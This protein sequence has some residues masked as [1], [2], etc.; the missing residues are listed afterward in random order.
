MKFKTNEYEA[1]KKEEPILIEIT[2]SK[3]EEESSFKKK[4]EVLP[5][6][7]KQTRLNLS[8]E[9]KKTIVEFIEEYGYHEV[10]DATGM[11]HENLR[12]LKSR[13]QENSSSKKRGRK[14]MFPELDLELSKWIIEK[15]LEKKK[16]TTKR[17]LTYAKMTAASKNCQ[18]ISFS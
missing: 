14:V 1:F 13:F 16:V 8:S 12:K 4:V 6:P 11:T 17:F 10:Q 18:G 2:T 5:K 7:K 15:R 9:E 3:S